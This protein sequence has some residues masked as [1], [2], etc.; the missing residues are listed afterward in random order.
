MSFIVDALTRTADGKTGARRV[1]TY[2][3][4]DEA[5]AAAQHV[6]DTFLFHEFIQGVGRGLTPEK[7]LDHY[8]RTGEVPLILREGGG[9][10]NVSSF[11]YRQ[12]AAKRCVEL[13]QGE[14]V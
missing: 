7:L 1:G 2:L 5:K 8:R 10:T 11:N 3:T 12:Y 13:F 4:H 9:S 14:K 6:I